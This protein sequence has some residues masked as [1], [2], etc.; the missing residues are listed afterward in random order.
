MKLHLLSILQQFHRA[1]HGCH[2]VE[3]ISLIQNSEK[4]M[5]RLYKSI[6]NKY[7]DKYAEKGFLQYKVLSTY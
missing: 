1:D 5:M 6:G 3:E 2:L 4:N 7:K